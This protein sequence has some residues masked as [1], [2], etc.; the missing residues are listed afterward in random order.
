MIQY[1]LTFITKYFRF[2]C[3]HFSL[4]TDDCTVSQQ[5]Q[6]NDGH[7]QYQR[8]QIENDSP[9]GFELNKRKNYDEMEMKWKCMCAHTS[10]TAHRH[11]RRL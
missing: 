8:N 2:V 9:L 4:F 7:E 11:M 5:Q 1:V 10:Q 6:G 3:V